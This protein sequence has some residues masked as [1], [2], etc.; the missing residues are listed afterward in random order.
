VQPGKSGDESP[1]SKA[2]M[3]PQGGA[4]GRGEHVGL[5]ADFGGDSPHGG[6]YDDAWPGGH[7]RRVPNVVRFGVVAVHVMGLC[8]EDLRMKKWRWL[9]VLRQVHKDQRGA[10]SLETI[11]ILGAIALPVLVFLVKVGWPKIRGYFET[12]TQKLDEGMQSEFPT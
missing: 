12:G 3:P 6:V 4:K 11:L 1:E 2:A 9:N 8:E 10:V 5:C 7:G